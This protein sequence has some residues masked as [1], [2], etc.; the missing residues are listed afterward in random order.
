MKKQIII[1]S[2]ILAIFSGYA[3]EIVPAD[4]TP[5]KVK[6]VKDY[7]PHRINMHVGTAF[8]N[9]IY[10]K[11]PEIQK[12]YSMGYLFD[13][14]YTYFFNKTVGLGIGVG[15]EDLSAKLKSNLYGTVPHLTYPQEGKMYD[16]LYSTN[17]LVEKQN[18][19]AIYV[20]LTV[21]FEHKFKEGKNGI[22]AGVGVQGYFPL[23]G[24]S[25]MKKG[26]LITRGYE[27]E[28]NVLYQNDM[29]Q[30]G[31]GTYNFKGVN[32][33]YNKTKEDLRASIDVVADFGGIF[34]INN[35]VDFY[36]GLF[37]SYGFLD[38]LPDAEFHHPYAEVAATEQ[39]VKYNGLLGS[40]YL[41]LY[42]EKYETNLKTAFNLFQVGVKVGIHI[43][44][45]SKVTKSLRNQFYEE[46]IKRAN[47]P[48]TAEQQK[49]QGE[50]EPRTITNT[51]IIYIIPQY[52]MPGEEPQSPFL[53]GTPLVGKQSSKEN[54]NIRELVEILS[55]TRILF[56]VD[57]DDPK[58]ANKDEE[59]INKVAEILK[60]DPS[61]I[62]I[63]E[64]YTD[65]TGSREHNIALGKRRAENTRNYFI[66][67][68]VSAEQIEIYS[69]T[70]DEPEAIQ[71]IQ[72]TSYAQK[73]AAIFRIKKKQ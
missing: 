45:C 6:K 23:I 8:T 40:N 28:V 63:V 20:P 27:E 21:Q 30:H 7:C 1:I 55:V 71:N 58:V 41:E 3:Q 12:I 14:G 29:P 31:F 65:P 73:R 56:D 54:A 72:S 48:I 67:K 19:Y 60:K 69:Y 62:L 57:K 39:N 15:I 17:E 25:K 64:G 4:T 33:I 24:V 13:I 11:S 50:Q 26:E 42:N 47:D 59:N 38:I 61:L 43:K 49:T 53:Q 36:V 9:N 52:T 16:L 18:L 32:K 10:G 34:E 35:K 5:I 2:L 68:G 37:G 46:M 51:E 22:Y 44:P 70:A 66:S